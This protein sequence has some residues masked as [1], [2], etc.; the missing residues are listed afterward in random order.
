LIGLDYNTV[1]VWFSRLEKARQHFI[2]HVGADLQ[3]HSRGDN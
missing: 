3:L 1:L 2:Q